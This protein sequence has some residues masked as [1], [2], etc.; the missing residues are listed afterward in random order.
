M[1]FTLQADLRTVIIQLIGNIY[2]N[3][4]IIKNINSENNALLFLKKLKDLFEGRIINEIKDDDEVYTLE[5]AT[6]FNKMNLIKLK[7]LFTD[8][9]TVEIATNKKIKKTIISFWNN[10]ERENQI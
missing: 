1:D 9:I 7:Q 8:D 2:F 3:K 4:K 6:L 5:I 10:I